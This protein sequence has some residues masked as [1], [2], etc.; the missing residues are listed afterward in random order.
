LFQV[1]DSTNNSIF[2][3]QG[4]G[5]AGYIGINQPNPPSSFFVNQSFEINISGGVADWNNKCSVFSNGTSSRSAGLGIALQ[6]SSSSSPV[7][8]L[9]LAPS[10]SWN[11]LKIAASSFVFE[12]QGGGTIFNISYLGSGTVYSNGGTLT[13]VNPSDIRLKTQVNTLNNNYNI[14]SNLRPVTFRWLDTNKHGNRVNIGFIAQEVQTV[15]SDIC[16]TYKVKREDAPMIL[17]SDGI[18]VDQYDEY[19]GY[20]PI[21]LIP[22]LVGAMKEQQLVIDDLKTRITALESRP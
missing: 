2:T 16:S 12:S 8:L 5:S 14:I 11:A 4:T 21:S 9:S 15:F 20:D 22:I 18:F 3:I 17:G 1:N 7:Y 13:N 10:N 19:L 6:N